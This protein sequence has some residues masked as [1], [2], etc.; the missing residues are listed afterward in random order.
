MK[1]KRMVKRFLAIGTGALMLGATAMGALAADLNDYPN[2]FVEDGKF[3]GLFV[4]GENA[5]SVDNLAMTDIA[6]NM[7]VAAGTATTTTNVE[8]DAWMVGTSTKS[9][10]MSNTNTTAVGEQIYD[11]E[12]WIS[13]EE[14][15]ALADGTYTTNA[16][17]YEFS[18]YL[19]FDTENQADNEI[20]VYIEGEQG[21]EDI[22]ADYFYVKSGDNIGEYKLEFSSSPESTVQTTAGAASTTGTVLDDIEDTTLSMFGKEYSVV[23]AR[24]PGSPAG[25]TVKLTLMGGATSGSILE[26]EST[27]VSINDIEYEVNLD[28][29]DATYAKFTV[30]GEQTAKLQ[31]GDTYK[32][33]DDTEIGVSE[34]LY[35]SYAGGVHS[36]D[37]FVGASKIVLQDD[38]ISD[39]ESSTELTVGSETV[40]GAEVIITG[41]DDST[42]FRLNTIQVNMTAQ[43]DYYVPAGGKLSDAI[44]DQD[45]EAE[46]LFTNN[47]D[48]EYMG[49]TDVETH[50]IKLTSTTD[51]K[52]KLQFYDG[53]GDLVK[54]PL[55]YALDATNITMSETGTDK[56]VLINEGQNVSKN[57]YFVITQYST[58]GSVDNSDGTG[59]TYALQY[60][61]ADKSSATSPKIKFKNLGSG[62]TLEYSVSTA[63]TDKVADIKLGGYTWS[64][65]NVSSKASSDFTLRVD[66]DGSAGT[67]ITA[68][69]TVG[70]NTE[71]DI[72]DY[73]GARIDFGGKA[74]IGSNPTQVLQP[75]AGGNATWTSIEFNIT[76]D[77]ADD[78]ENQEP[79]TIVVQATGTT[80]T[81]VTVDNFDVDGT[82]F[83]ITP[84][85]EENVGYG[86]TT[87]GAKWTYASPSGSPNEFTLEYPKT[88]RLPQVYITSG[89]TTSTSSSGGDMVAVEV[90]LATKLDSEVASATAENLIVVGGPCVNSVAAELMGNPADC[91]EGF[92]PGKAV[93]KLF[94]NGDKVAMLVA[95]YSGA[96]TRLAGKVVAEQPSKLSGMEVEIEGTTLAD[97]SVGA[98]TVVE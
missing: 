9:L 90:G 24:R 91:T 65:A 40:D 71:M 83:S 77:N 10:E 57:D 95:G 60:K 87:Q 20:V 2:M 15:G 64:F 70:D 8:G 56:E 59:K 4:V 58:A 6:A 5:A 73:F 74:T 97:V 84:D 62:E 75:L 82:D 49:L 29:V 22:T 76:T 3:N 44:L 85:G 12:Q 93:V 1:V 19:Y 38:N 43:D 89:A 45:D 63:T 11:V 23:L 13:E 7:K 39:T 30:N 86:Y 28:Y 14:L 25:Q 48:L 17:S 36:T 55:F 41:T 32:L 27:T 94:E 18:Q 98:P 21:D 53:D 78:Y 50:E 42:T 68:E 79:P 33:A 69:S 47:W 46:L 51:R 67:G 80:G 35:Q 72:V 66:M 61:G 16:G 92:T 26:G 96:D 81:E 54:M 37:F 52:Y 88:Q 31:Q 34:I